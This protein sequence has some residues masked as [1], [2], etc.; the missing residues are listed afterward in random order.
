MTKLEKLEAARAALNDAC[1]DYYDA[2]EAAEAA[3]DAALYAYYAAK[4]AYQDELKKT[5]RNVMHDKPQ[6]TQDAAE[7][8]AAALK[9]LANIADAFDENELDD[10]ARKHWGLEN[11]HTN[12]TPCHLIELFSGRGGRSLLTLADA[13]FARRALETMNGLKEQAHD[14]ESRS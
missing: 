2:L 10:E 13:M 12:Q 8:L 7:T 1:G 9:P 14:R 6:K 3:Y 4:T 5:R 11:E